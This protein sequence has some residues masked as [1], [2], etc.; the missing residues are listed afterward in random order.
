MTITDDD[1]ARFAAQG[2]A[3]LPL[4]GR[5]GYVAHRG[6]RI[7]QAQFGSGAPVILL[8]GGL[9]NSGNWG[10]Q[11]PALV[12]AGYAVTVID[13]RGHGRSTR[14]GQPYSYDL[15][16][17]DVLAVMDELEMPKAAIVGWSD[18]ACAGLALARSHPERVSG[19]LFFAC[20]VDA[21]GTKPF[22]PTSVIDNCF[23]RHVADYAALSVTP[24]DFKAFSEA[25]GVMQRTLP[26]YSPADLAGIDAPV[27][28]LQSTDDEFI[29]TEHAEYLA[30][31]LPRARLRLLE[32][33][34]HFAPLQRPHLFNAE[35]LDF[36][37]TLPSD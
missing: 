34:T 7:W 36:L 10:Y 6:A 21:S 24:D 26:D 17:A 29:K 4:T 35:V 3:P 15:L 1:L 30:R 27:L 37:A 18:G 20:N 8:H 14:D 25:V 22:V 31:T 12:E 5:Q 33:V 16:A 19:V 2:A 9:G 32:G 28:V 11:V 13:S 23:S